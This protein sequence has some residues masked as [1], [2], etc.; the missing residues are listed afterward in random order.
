MLQFYDG[1]WTPCFFIF[2]LWW[3][4]SFYLSQI[5][6]I[7]QLLN[8]RGLFYAY[9]QSMLVVL[10]ESIS[11]CLSSVFI[12]FV[13]LYQTLQIT[14]RERDNLISSMICFQ[15]LNLTHN[16]PNK[17]NRLLLEFGTLSKTV[18]K[19]IFLIKFL[20]KFE[21]KADNFMMEIEFWV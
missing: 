18:E 19:L 15:S 2:K 16:F 4:H 21:T 1:N 10:E 13:I 7:N 20:L 17:W 11:V 3:F 5:L 6:Y 14:L 12:V 8:K 9:V